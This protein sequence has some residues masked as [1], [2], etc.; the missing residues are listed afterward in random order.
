MGRQGL[1]AKRSPLASG[2]GN[3]KSNHGRGSCT[4]IDQS[5]KAS[6]NSVPPPA[7]LHQIP[8]SESPSGSASRTIRRQQMPVAQQNPRSRSPLDDDTALVRAIFGN[9]PA[10]PCESGVR[11]ELFP[12]ER[13]TGFIQPGAP[14][15]HVLSTPPGPGSCWVP[16]AAVLFDG[17]LMERSLNILLV[18][19]HGKLGC[20]PVPPLTDN[21]YSFSRVCACKS[22]HMTGGNLMAQ[23]WGASTRS[24]I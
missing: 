6:Y 15:E 17:A 12:T 7:S 3:G 9:R 23:D 19:M 4:P 20:T 1:G 13:T 18:A 16:T 22:R 2:R 11:M 8:S 5:N 21:H 14:S 10:Q 24:L